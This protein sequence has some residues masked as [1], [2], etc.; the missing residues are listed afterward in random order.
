MNQ[1]IESSWSAGL[2][3]MR[4][5]GG[6]FGTVYKAIEKDT[7]DIVAIKHVWTL[8]TRLRRGWSLTDGLTDDDNRLI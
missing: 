3:L 7:G 1:T 5:Q 8:P 4:K 6:S 2:G